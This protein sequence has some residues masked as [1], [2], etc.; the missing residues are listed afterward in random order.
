MR[1]GIHPDRDR[2]FSDKWR[3]FLT[4]RGV[5][6]VLLDLLGPQAIE[7]AKS[8]DG[9]MR[10]WFH[11]QDDKQSARVILQAIESSLKKPVFPSVAT[12]W[13]FDDKIA[14]YYLL[15]ALGAPQPAAWVWWE[16]E[17]AL[18]WTKS[19]SYPVI[20]KLT[21][22]AG[23]S[24]VVK[25]E[26]RQD[27]MS[28]IDQMF[29]RGIFPMMMNEY[30]PAFLPKTRRQAKQRALRFVD[31]ARH[32]VAGEFPALPDAWWKP[33]K[34]YAFFQEFLPGNEYDT[35]V[36][37]VGERA[38][39]FRRMNRPGD[40]RASGSGNIDWNPEAVDPACLELAFEVSRKAD[41]QT[42][43]YDFL[44]RNGKPVI[45]EISYTFVDTAVHSC[46]G[47]WDR[48]LQW[49]EGHMWPQEAQ[50]EDFIEEVGNRRRGATPQATVP[51][52]TVTG[53]QG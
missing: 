25:V 43:A 30:R 45:C 1:I 32:I 18:E 20:F 31:A 26:T 52:A 2:A 36:T 40:F 28:L 44:Y 47:H 15:S 23:S 10:R 14:Q 9:I 37:V 39:A 19:A 53:T 38:F 33:E 41:F 46:P 16:K 50:V 27:A 21:A 5:E 35:R 42:M 11:I 22:G 49:H 51:G 6:V 17:R 4:E 12:S 34:G 48:Q 8:C 13:H 24:N 3:D 29:D 7:E